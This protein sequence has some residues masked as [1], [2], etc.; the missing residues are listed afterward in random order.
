MKLKNGNKKGES[1]SFSFSS[2][3]ESVF[4][5]KVSSVAHTRQK[6]FLIKNSFFRSLG[7]SLIKKSLEEKKRK[8]KR[9]LALKPVKTGSQN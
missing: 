6:N 4:F 1:P 3:S 9:R 2:L 8:R 5:V 7:N